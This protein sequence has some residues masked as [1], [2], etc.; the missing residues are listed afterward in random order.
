MAKFNLLELGK[1]FIAHHYGEK[2]GKMLIHTGVIGWA[3]SATA[4]IIAIATNDKLKKEQK[5]YMI[6]QEAADALFNVASF[7]LVTQTFSTV[8][9]KLVKTGKWLPKSIAQHLKNQN[10]TNI[11]HPNFSVL[12]H[13]NLNEDLT[14]IYNKHNFGINLGLTTLGSVISCNILTPIFRN[15]VATH[16]QK[17]IMECLNNREKKNSVENLTSNYIKPIDFN[18]FRSGSLKI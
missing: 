17:K 15:K 3:L 12:E 9:S 10:L 8:A 13:G 11:G 1:D 6:P 5:V 4:Q 14:N 16:R 2:P 18:T 7:Y